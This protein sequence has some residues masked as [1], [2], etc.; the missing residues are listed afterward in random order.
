NSG[1]P[2]NLFVIYV[3]LPALIMVKVPTMIENLDLSGSWW[4]PISMIWLAFFLAIG[5]I[6][7][8]S[9]LFLWSAHTTGALMLTVGL[10]NTS[11]VG[12]PILEALLGKKA[13][14]IGIL[15]DQGGSFLLV[16]TLGIVIASLFSGEPIKS[17]DILRRLFL[18]PPFI[19]IL[20]A[21]IWYLLGTPGAQVIL[22][23]FGAIAATLI[24]LALFAV[25]FQFKVNVEVLQRRGGALLLGLTLKL[26]FIPFLCWLLYW[27]GLGLTNFFTRVSILEAAMATQ[28]T[29]GVVAVEYG[30]DP[31]IAQLMV[32]LSVP[33]SIVTVSLWQYFI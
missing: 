18:F 3:S 26:F 8:F 4:I 5:L 33:L 31:E 1:Q 9:K 29:A 27:K 16:S 14:N 32:T 10:G 11:F 7:I 13:I 12:F 6:F 25:G 2:L 21:V 24:P 22:P 30:L 19:A 17:R 15:A 20:L 23:A 28:I